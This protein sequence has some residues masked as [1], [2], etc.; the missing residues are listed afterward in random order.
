MWIQS[1]FIYT[2]EGGRQV[3]WGNYLCFR[4][5]QSAVLYLSLQALI[6]N[7]FAHFPA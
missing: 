1:R 5:R 4:F 2:A 6:L 3:I 7:C